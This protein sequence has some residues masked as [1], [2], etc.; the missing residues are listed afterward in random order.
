MIRDAEILITGGY[1]FIGS[2]I[3]EKLV[4]PELGNAVTLLDIN[5]GSGTTGNALGLNQVPD[6]TTVEASITDAENLEDLP[7]RYDYIIHAA[8]YLGINNVAQQQA[9]TMDTNIMGTRN[10]LD[11]AARHRETP[12]FLYFSTSEIYGTDSAGSKEDD[13][14]AI[15]SSGSRWCYATSK[16]A[17]EYYLRAYSQ[18]YGISGGI[19]R[20]FNVFGPHR[21]GS[22]AMTTLVS[23]AVIDEDL[24]ISG[25]GQQVRAWCYIDDFCDG[26]IRILERPSD[27]I[28]AFN[29]GDDTH[30][31][32]MAGLADEIVRAAGSK[33]K[34]ELLHDSIED[35]RYRI[36]NIDKARLYLGYEP[37]TDF[38]IALGNVVE[39][40]QAAAIGRDDTHVKI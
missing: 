27:G 1:G 30:V 35:V 10:I 40:A 4:Q 6:I 23:K 37:K 20:P 21:N 34:I 22:N 13:P 18:T 5:T 9:L 12:G 38:Q 2:H 15:P 28:E 39:W 8:G 31:F 33:S 11:F 14:V 7:T 24:K 26:A 16:I 29:I 25:D 32:T 3:A 19:V 17:G 36:P